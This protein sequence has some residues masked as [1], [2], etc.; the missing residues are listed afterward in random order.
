MKLTAY[1]V[2]ANVVAAPDPDGAIAVM[3][4]CEPPG[5]W[6]LDDVRALDEEELYQPVDAGGYSTVY[7][8]LSTPASAHLI[9]WDFPGI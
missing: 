2:G 7:D 9:R 5:R 3:E 8:Q 6:T 4:R 1:Y